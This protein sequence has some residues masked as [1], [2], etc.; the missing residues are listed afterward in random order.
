L[1]CKRKQIDQNKITLTY[2]ISAII[3]SAIIAN[4]IIILSDSLNKR[5]S[6]ILILNITAA[7]A[8]SLGMIAVY[9]HGL[10]GIHGKS[11]LFLTLGLICWLSAD[12]SLA[13]YYFALGIEEQ[14]LVSV[15]DVLWFAGYAFL[16]LHL[17]TVLSYICSKINLST[18]II[19]SIATLLFITYNVFYLISSSSQFL[20]VGD[21]D[22]FVVTIAYPILDLILI[23]PSVL[24]LVNLR[25][26]Y[27][28]FIPWFLSSLSLLVNSI[29]DDGYMNDFVN[30]RL[31][32][33]SFWDMFYVTDFIIIAGA[34]FW[35]NRFHISYKQRRM[36]VTS[37]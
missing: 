34:L 31:Q 18:V 15:T 7:I 9:R 32:N 21:I 33:L 19:A 35:Y 23:V 11:Y 6:T 28:Q 10:H 25:K 16:A 26:D 37:S 20:V 30:G 22:A 29:A 1:I 12:L 36:K 4:S 27:L 5:S 13:Y 24:V 2:F 14:I 3:I 8:S 17:F